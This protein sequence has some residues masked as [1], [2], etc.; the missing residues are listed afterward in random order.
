MRNFIIVFVLA[1][2]SCGNNSEISK[3]IYFNN[4]EINIPSYL[5][6]ESSSSC[7]NEINLKDAKENTT[8]QLKLCDYGLK[9]GRQSYQQ[10]NGFFLEE[11]A[12]LK[13]EV[14]E[15]IFVD[16]KSLNNGNYYSFTHEFKIGENHYS[17]NYIAFEK[18]YLTIRF[19]STL[20]ENIPELRQV[21]EKI[22]KG[23]LS[24]YIDLKEDKKD[25]Y[26]CQSPLF[27]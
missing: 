20:K 1:F 10:L 12:V 16:K 9:T 25:C 26:Y 23:D 6:I 8:I 27:W 4:S 24:D 5:T 15:S 3:V 7:E 18:Y 2:M 13:E 11:C 17:N 22:I 19:Q 14:P 21:V